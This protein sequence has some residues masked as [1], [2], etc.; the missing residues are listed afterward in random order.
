MLLYNNM[1]QS[2][3]FSEP[4]V[5]HQQHRKNTG[6]FFPVPWSHRSFSFADAPCNGEPRPHKPACTSHARAAQPSGDTLRPPERC[7]E[8][9]KKKRATE[10]K[11]ARYPSHA[12]TCNGRGK[13]ISVGYEARMSVEDGFP[14]PLLNIKKERP[15]ASDGFPKR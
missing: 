12:K 11:A 5:F 2:F 4:D 9:V 7:K 6:I 14:A 3:S 8:S 1:E 15:A 10:P 13:R